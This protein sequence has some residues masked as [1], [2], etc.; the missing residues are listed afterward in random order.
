[1]KNN[2]IFLRPAATLFF[3]TKE[4][5]ARLFR[6]ADTMKYHRKKLFRKL[7]VETISEALDLIA[8]PTDVYLSWHILIDGVFINEA[9]RIRREGRAFVAVGLGCCCYCC[10][11]QKA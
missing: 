1:M 7:G 4:I 9:H 5:A 2:P 11:D 3:K 10:H 6:T 8:N